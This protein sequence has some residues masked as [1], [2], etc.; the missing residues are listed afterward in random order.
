MFDWVTIVFSEQK[1]KII[2]QKSDKTNVIGY[3]VCFTVKRKN[4]ITIIFH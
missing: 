3:L 1:M 2:L 4:G